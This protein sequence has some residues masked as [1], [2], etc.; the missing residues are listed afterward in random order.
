[1]KKIRFILLLLCALLC[2]SASAEN[3]LDARI[4]EIYT[5]HELTFFLTEDGALFVTGNTDGNS[6]ISG[7][8]LPYFID[9]NVEKICVDYAFTY[10][11]LYMKK[12]GTVWSRAL[13]Y[14]FG[15][16]S[17]P[18]EPSFIID[19]AKDIFLYFQ[20][21]YII[22][23][24]GSLWSMGDLNSTGMLGNGTKKASPTPVKVMENA[25][26]VYGFPGG[27]YVHVL[28]ED[29]KLYGIG[30]DPDF[31]VLGDGTK[32]YR[33]TP[34]LI[35]EN[36]KE[37]YN[38]IRETFALTNN[39]ELYAWG[40]N[41]KM[42]SQGI[43]YWNYLGNGGSTH[44]KK[45]AKILDNVRDFV[46]DHTRTE[47]FYAVTE[48]DKLW[49]WGGHHAKS[50]AITGNGERGALKVPTVIMEPECG[51]RELGADYVILN[52]NTL[53]VWG[54]M[55]G[56]L[57]VALSPTCIA[58]N[59]K[60]YRNT[61]GSVFNSLTRTGNSYLD[62]DNRMWS[63]Y[64]YSVQDGGNYQI[65]VNSLAEPVLVMENVE[66]FSDYNEHFARTLDGKL[67]VWSYPVALGN[68]MA[69]DGAHYQWPPYELSL[70]AYYPGWLV[71]ELT[72]QP[73][74]ANPVIKQ[75]I[76]GSSTF[77]LMEDGRL[78]GWGSNGG[79]LG[80]TYTAR[81]PLPTFI[82]GD[83][84]WV[85]IR[86]SYSP[87][88]VLKKNGDV[89]YWESWDDQK[90]LESITPKLAASNVKKVLDYGS[91]LIYLDQNDNLWRYH[92]SIGHVCMAEQV[93]SFT[94]TAYENYYIT[95]DKSLWHYSPRTSQ[96]TL[97]NAGSWRQVASDASSNAYL[98]DENGDL[99]TLGSINKQRGLDQH[100]PAFL[101]GNVSELITMPESML[102]Y[103][104]LTDGSLWSLVD[105]C[106]YRVN[107]SY[108]GYTLNPR[109]LAEDVC[110][111]GET[112][113]RLYLLTS[114]GDL[115]EYEWIQRSNDTLTVPQ[116]LLTNVRA[117]DVAN[118]WDKFCMA[119]THDGGIWLWGDGIFRKGFIEYANTEYSIDAPVRIGECPGAADIFADSC[120]LF[121]VMTEDGSLL[122]SGEQ[123]SAMGVYT[124][125]A[126]PLALVPVQLNQ[127]QR[128][129]QTVTATPLAAA[130]A[131]SAVKAAEQGEAPAPTGT[132]APTDAPAVV[133]QTLKQGSKGTDVLEMKKR[134]QELG[135]FKK[136]AELSNVYNG[137]C[138][139]RVKQFQK[140]NG[141]P[142]TGVA[143]TETL[144]LLYSD[145][146][147][148]K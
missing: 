60:A 61:K 92:S 147:L 66:R 32:K 112:E 95:K 39:G 37:V 19:G 146:A 101:L 33:T 86:N 55:P 48:D 25:K 38:G 117:M 4:R 102:V 26:A 41:G 141:L 76:P 63:W 23:Q 137:T 7:S 83:V 47:T 131:A 1:M 140:K 126:D 46:C 3:R 142:Q 43:T 115:W 109:M 81:V 65:N 97:L 113:D 53:W 128:N 31:Y 125:P 45:P 40:V 144:S 89:F 134:M 78:W 24:D 17:Y 50:I 54:S 18:T 139:E 12:D 96:S 14:S 90:T 10:D 110:E 133:Y 127:G 8:P 119:I 111:Y 22:R 79:Y 130:T 80:T 70:E 67:Y 107:G 77:A 99:Y 62:M 72:G 5:A 123:P 87:V 51:I 20:N 29:G 135:Y 57:E 129:E 132:E 52:D 16:N 85:Y 138:V 68:G 30:G 91:S 73:E 44:L 75:M 34:V 9:S 69:M 118:N 74:K 71:A 94:N 64:E 116:K 59:V 13:D 145:Q 28:A 11:F 15:Y 136:G 6:G 58:E 84:E 93:I 148:P 35:M 100:E 49:A 36:V 98:L 2:C 108:L 103:A 104:L 88:W 82:M 42:T 114:C 122:A 121:F 143:D 120:N 56:N 124:L 105:F 106:D 21:Y 27:S